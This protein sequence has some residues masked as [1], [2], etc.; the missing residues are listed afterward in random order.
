MKKLKWGILSTANIGKE[1]VIP[2]IKRAEN[3]DVVAIASRNE[4][5]AKEAAEEL[6]IPKTFSSYEALLEDPEIDAVYIPLPNG[7]HKEWVIKAAE[8][9]KHVLCEKPAAIT[10]EELDEM[11]AVCHTNNVT[12]MEAFMYQFH[13]QHEKVKEL[14]RDGEIGDISFMN[15]D[16]S[17]YQRDHTNIRLNKDLGGGAMFDAGCY[18]LH[19]IRNIL[20]QEPTSAYA[21]AHYDAELDVD[22]TMA[23]VLN[24]DN[25]LVA[26]FNTSFDAISRDGYEVDGTYWNGI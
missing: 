18:T 19:A 16:F 3:A 25:G 17:F 10:K 12:F 5:T 4:Q 21:S 20:D 1:Q 2:A 9:K 11:I 7:L 8:K 22:L 13:P 26:T 23:G 6:N 14:I 24:F 15:A